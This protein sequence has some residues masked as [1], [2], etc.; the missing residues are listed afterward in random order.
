MGFSYFTLHGN[1]P[2]LD[3]HLRKAHIER[4]AF[5]YATFK[6]IKRTAAAGASVLAE[7]IGHWRRASRTSRAL[8]TLSDRQLH[9]IGIDR[10]DI[11]DVSKL[12][13]DPSSRFG[14]T[15][16]DLHRM[17]FPRP[18][19][20]HAPVAPLPRED[21]RRHRPTVRAVSRPSRPGTALRETAS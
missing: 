6:V 13:A 17:G 19:R 15:L 14:I 16:E 9:D 21:K 10:A 1:S 18:I 2:E 5:V 20:T 12:A 3:A 7:S 4:A 11:G 8:S